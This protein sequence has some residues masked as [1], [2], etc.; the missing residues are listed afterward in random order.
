[1]GREGGGGGCLYHP[2]ALWRR[3]GRW[4]VKKWLYKI[5]KY[6]RGG[7][8]CGGGDGRDHSGAGRGGDG[9][10]CAAAGRTLMILN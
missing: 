4:W 7:Q 2:A 8:S 9:T 5:E 1:M 3:R 10:T 6:E